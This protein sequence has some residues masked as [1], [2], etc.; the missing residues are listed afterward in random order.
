MTAQPSAR[1]DWSAF[2]T[3]TRT[4]A[5]FDADKG[6]RATLGAWTR[7]ICPIIHVAVSDQRGEIGREG[8]AGES[9]LFVDPCFPAFDRAFVRL[10]SARAGLEVHEALGTK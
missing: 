5:S 1:A 6:R 4:H 7:T 9:E 8:R 10:G 3:G 2:G